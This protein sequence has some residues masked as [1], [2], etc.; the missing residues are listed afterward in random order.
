M[1]LLV[2]LRVRGSIC[3]IVGVCLVCDFGC[4][5]GCLWLAFRFVILVVSGVSCLVF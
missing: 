5:L 4:L 2:S 3:V 1:N